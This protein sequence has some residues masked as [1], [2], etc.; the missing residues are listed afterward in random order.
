MKFKEFMQS[1]WVQR[2]KQAGVESKIKKSFPSWVRHVGNKSLIG[3]AQQLW[4]H[5]KEGK[6][7]PKEK[8]ILMAGLL[9]L[10]SPVDAMPDFI[11]ILG[12]L[13]DAGV[14]SFILLYLTGNMTDE[15]MDEQM[16]DLKNV[17]PQKDK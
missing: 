15:E 10:I 16:G 13:D 9:Y 17:T 4:N 1:K 12:W 7:T 14:A 5:F 11:P 2:A 8:L 6:S 3:S